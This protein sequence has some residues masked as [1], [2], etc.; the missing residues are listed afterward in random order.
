MEEIDGLDGAELSASS[1]LIHFDR[2]I[3]LLRIPLHST[4]AVLA[5]RD[6]D[7]WSA[8]LQ[9][10]QAKVFEQCQ[11]G[12]RVGCAVSAS[13]KCSPP[14]W[15][16]LLG[17]SMADFVERE[18]CEERETAA[19]LEASKPTCHRFAQ[20]KCLP[21]FRDARISCSFLS[22]D[23]PN[24]RAVDQNCLRGSDLLEKFF[25]GG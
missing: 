9:S 11:S 17:L 14:W 2:P 25:A 24:H 6:A 12:A 8:A 1:T 23:Y 22:S 7:S 13:K 15:K 10:T 21:A 18:K 20:E 16:N 4:P 3:P 19:C 5:F